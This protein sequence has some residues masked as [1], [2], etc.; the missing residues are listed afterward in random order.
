M[1]FR[2][3]DMIDCK[4]DLTE[5]LFRIVLEIYHKHLDKHQCVSCLLFEYTV[6]QQCCTRYT[7]SI[8]LKQPGITTK[9]QLSRI[10]FHKLHDNTW[11]C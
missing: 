1:L 6:P 5:M 8:I 7:E 4:S 2:I 10:G 11:K 3:P 9:T